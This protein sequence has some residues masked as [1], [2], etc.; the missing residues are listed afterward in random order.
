[1]C[2]NIKEVMNL[3]GAGTEHRKSRRE[4]REWK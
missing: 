1:M 2:N 4:K 3:R